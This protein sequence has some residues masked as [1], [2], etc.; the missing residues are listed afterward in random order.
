METVVD[1]MLAIAQSIREE[2]TA[3]LLLKIFG[4]T[5]EDIN[6]IIETVKKVRLYL[7]YEILA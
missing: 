6:Q 5:G 7:L 1:S 4:R 2:L 3:V